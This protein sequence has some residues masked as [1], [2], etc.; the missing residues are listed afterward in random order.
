MVDRLSLGP[1]TMQVALVTFS[2][3][4]S[5]AFPLNRSHDNA[6][7]KRLILDTAKQGGTSV[8]I[9]QALDK[10][11]AEVLLPSN[12]ARNIAVKVAYIVTGGG[13]DGDVNAT[14]SSANQLKNEGLVILGLGVG[15]NASDVDQLRRIVSLSERLLTVH[16]FSQLRGNDQL[17]DV[18]A[19]SICNSS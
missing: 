6:I 10:V 12:G 19:E 16:Q 7:V 5:I 18:V 8:N 17:Y 4:A 14:E 15:L 11:L 2:D 9:T 1:I 3:T 13:L